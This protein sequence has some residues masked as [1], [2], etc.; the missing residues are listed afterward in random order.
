MRTLLLIVLLLAS[1]FSVA[2]DRC[3]SAGYA[4]VVKTSSPSEAARIA[5]AE[6]FLQ[7][8]SVASIANARTVAPTLV[9][10]IPVVVHVIYKNTT[11]NISDAQVKSQ[12]DA[13]NRDFRRTNSDTLNTPERFRRV[14][15]DVQIEFYLATSD[16]K[17]RGTSGIV[18]KQTTVTNF[19]NNDK[20]KFSAQGGDDAW[21][22]KSYLN[23]WVGR[24]ISGAG[25]SSVPGSDP[26][27]DGIVI[28]VGSFGTINVSGYYNLGR[29]TA[30]EVGHWLGLKHIWG[31]AQCGD[32]GVSDTPQQGWYTQQCPTGFRSSCSN[33]E[34]GDMYMNYMD[35]TADACMN[36]FTEGQK[37]RMRASFSQGGPRETLLQSKGLKEPWA[38][39]SGVPATATKFSLYPN[40]AKDELNVSLGAEWV[41]KT[42]SLINMN[43]T[44]VQTVQVKSAVQKLNISS[45]KAGMYFLKGEGISEKFIKL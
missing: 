13:L 35:Y 41:G 19:L 34:L 29:T 31:D 30:H 20:I 37:A 9:V 43:G 33:G 3:A 26:S 5:E 16:P 25:Y 39:E 21:D 18:R 14:A 44:I 36:L 17:G 7:K 42:I 38:A 2:Q 8:R 10:K 1:I 24:L 11:E 15:A 28:N 32:D 27:K 6:N 22:S 40:P 12:I 23:I 4:D 45:L